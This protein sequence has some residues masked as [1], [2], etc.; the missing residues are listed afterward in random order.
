MLRQA[1]IRKNL[2]QSDV[3]RL[4]GMA[5]EWYGRIERG[6]ALGSLETLAMLRI[7]LAFDANQQ[8]AVLAEHPLPI[9]MSPRKPRTRGSLVRGPHLAFGD[10]IKAARLELRL[11]C[12]TVASAIGTSVTF[13]GRIEAGRA[14]PAIGTFAR[15]RLCLGFDAN[16]LLDVLSEPPNP[17]A[18]LGRLIRRA[19]LHRVMTAD[20]VAEEIDCPIERYRYIESG[21]ALPTTIAFARLHRLLE[22]DA[23]KALDAVPLQ[24]VISSEDV[25]CPYLEFGTLLRQARLERRLAHADLIQSVGGTE[26][27]W[28]RMEA[29]LHVPSTRKL[30]ALHRCLGFDA[31]QL[32]G[33]L[34]RERASF[35]AFGQLL[36]DARQRC[37]LAPAQV[38]SAAGCTVEHYQRVE[39]GAELPS[40]M[41]LVRLHRALEFNA[42]RALLA[43]PLDAP[44]RV[45]R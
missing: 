29:G 33:A 13:L 20:E 44:A 34:H 18:G 40:M 16:H 15:L 39:R 2:R 6:H 32:L 27:Y 36:G 4:T 30:A 41:M 14:L 9:A 21:A 42:D 31:N 45:S 1:R 23:D 22:F 11:E 35:R 12:T 7:V 3:A 8:L 19:R 17:F 37:N 5:E 43:I 25:L 10:L 38:A 26:T 24:P 28:T